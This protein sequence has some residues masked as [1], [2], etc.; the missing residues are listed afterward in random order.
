VAAHVTADTGT[1]PVT[2]LRAG[3]AVLGAYGYV[4][5]LLLARHDLNPEPVATIR[6]WLNRPLGLG[7]D[8][9]PLAVMLLLA[10]AGLQPR[11]LC[12]VGLSVLATVCVCLFVYDDPARL[13]AFL[14]LLLVG[15]V[16]WS[17]V[18][19][20]LSALAGVPLGVGCLAVVVA[21]DRGFPGLQPWWYP[22]AATFAVLLFLVVARPGPTATAVAGHPVTRGLAVV[23]EAPFV[24]GAVLVLVGA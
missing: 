17:V 5:G 4:L 24:A 11:R 18:D 23:A 19:G 10:A 15:Y 3:A 6:T 14:P 9:G 20:R 13:L 2:L 12:Q 16:T 8:F 1:A 21:A 7:E 22:V